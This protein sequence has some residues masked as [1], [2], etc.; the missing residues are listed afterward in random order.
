L[1]YSNCKTALIAACNLTVSA[2]LR[3]SFFDDI[4]RE[5]RRVK[6]KKFFKSAI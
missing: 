3:A 2:I 4:S 1:G 5:N 6:T